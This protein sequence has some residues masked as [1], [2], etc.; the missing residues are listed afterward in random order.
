M[1][2]PQFLQSALWSCKVRQLNYRRD[3]IYIITQILNYGTWP[4][5]K[6]LLKTY[7]IR[8]I[9][10]VLRHPDRG[11]WYDEVLNYWL[12]LF[13]MKI[14]RSTYEAALRIIGPRSIKLPYAKSSL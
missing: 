13:N 6:W 11:T 10:Y 8:D 9:K 4:Q 2:V 7:S 5:L 3:K 1:A 12:S 14:P